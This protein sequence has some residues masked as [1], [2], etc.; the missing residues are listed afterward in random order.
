MTST[1]SKH[2]FTILD[3]A[4]RLPFAPL[5]AELFAARLHARPAGIPTQNLNSRY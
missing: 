5:A 4:S 1:A 3:D 2:R